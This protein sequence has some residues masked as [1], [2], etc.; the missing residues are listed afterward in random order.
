MNPTSR[1]KQEESPKM[2]RQRNNPQPKGKEESPETFL[3]KIEAIKIS[4]I[5]QLVQNNGYKNA[6]G[7]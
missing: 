1:K 5:K 4:D 3:N 2:G 6:Q 7:A